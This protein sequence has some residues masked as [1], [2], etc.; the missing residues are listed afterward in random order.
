MRDIRRQSH[1]GPP[2]PVP[3][4]DREDPRLRLASDDA[5]SHGKTLTI[6]GERLAV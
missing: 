2:S 1:L 4:G 6:D 3:S 5:R